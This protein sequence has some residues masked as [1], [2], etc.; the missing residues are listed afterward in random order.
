M[1]KKS[2]QKRNVSTDSDNSE[3][4][5]LDEQQQEHEIQSLENSH[6]IK[7]SSVKWV[8]FA[9]GLM[10]LAVNAFNIWKL[11]FT[12]PKIFTLLSFVEGT[13]RVLRICNRGKYLSFA[14]SCSA[15][16][17]F[18]V[19][20]GAFPIVLDEDLVFFPVVFNAIVQLFL[21]DMLS[22]ENDIEELKKLKY[23]LKGA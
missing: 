3:S 14:L 22:E 2:L 6:R 10:F 17:V 1:P 11:G 16:L 20:N 8:L 19:M 18:V 5:L 15:A 7:K 12:I 23:H 4:E 21:A 9:I 13:V